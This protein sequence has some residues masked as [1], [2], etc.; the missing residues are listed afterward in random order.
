MWCYRD[1]L[2]F[3]TKSMLF[4]FINLVDNFPKILVSQ[5]I[6][7]FEKLFP[8]G[9]VYSHFFFVSVWLFQLCECL[10][11]RIVVLREKGFSSN[12]LECY[13]VLRLRKIWLHYLIVLF[14]IYIRLYKIT[15]C[16]MLNDHFH[17]WYHI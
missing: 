12:I 15:K 13:H 17:F 11:M 16:K 1:F 7:Y 3:S 2:L 5:C 14:K 8:C 4:L 9:L 6:N 10:Q